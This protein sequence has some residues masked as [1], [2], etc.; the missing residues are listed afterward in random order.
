MKSK[1][2][3]LFGAD[4]RSLAALRIGVA[5]VLIVDLCQRT[6]DL[7]AHYS[8]FGV[9][10]RSL[11]ID[12]LGSRWFVSLHFLSGTWQVQALLFL[13]AG[14]FAVALLIGYRTRLATVCSWF[15]CVSL[16]VRN[17]HVVASGDMLLRAISQERPRLPRELDRQ[18]NAI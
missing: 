14:V 8:D 4:L 16:N 3:E 17:F 6:S 11:A 2:E 5:L 13:L 1:I 7:E 12:N 15:L 10:P 9:A 18:K